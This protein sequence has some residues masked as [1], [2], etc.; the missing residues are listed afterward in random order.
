MDE[1]GQFVPSFYPLLN[2][3]FC[4]IKKKKGIEI[5]ACLSDRVLYHNM[6]IL[7]IPI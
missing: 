5:Q 2:S 3:V 6:E 1:E 7:C 4:F